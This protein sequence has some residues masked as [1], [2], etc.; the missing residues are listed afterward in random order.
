[1]AKLVI[2]LI[3]NCRVTVLNKSIVTKLEIG[4]HDSTRC[5]V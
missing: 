4:N 1:M 5:V 3:W 2:K